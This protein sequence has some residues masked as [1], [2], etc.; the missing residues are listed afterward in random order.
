VR[1]KLKYIFNPNT[2]VTGSEF[3]KYMGEPFAETCSDIKPLGLTD[4]GKSRLIWR[5]VGN[6]FM[7]RIPEH[8]QL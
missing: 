5:Y 7:D 3:V 4:N 1:Q 6:R 2:N 8:A